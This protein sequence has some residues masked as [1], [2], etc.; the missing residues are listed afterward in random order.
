LDCV[1]LEIM[2]RA[3]MVED[4]KQLGFA[5]GWLAGFEIDLTQPEEK[6]FGNMES[7]RRRCI[8]LTERNGV[9]I[10]ESGDIEFAA[11][12]HHQLKEVFRRQ[13]LVPTYTVERVRQLITHL[14]PTGRLLLLRARSKDGRCIATGIFPALNRTMYFWG[15]ASL[16][17]YHHLHPNEAIHWYAMR[18]WKQRG[19]HVYDMGGGGDY[20]GRYGGYKIQ[21]P[22]VRIS[23]YPWIPPM[24]ELSRHVMRWRQLCL[25]KVER[26]LSK[27]QS[28]LPVEQK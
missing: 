4:L 13:T 26:V 25:G 3:L 27:L 16:R 2:D 9:T 23:K 10:E 28:N 12:Y 1:H 15:G 21:V 11:D 18:Y 5:H 14:Y 20:K 8:R 19:M 22:W 6:L 17:E 7:D 24:R